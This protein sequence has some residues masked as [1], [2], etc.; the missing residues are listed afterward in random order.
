MTHYL[1]KAASEDADWTIDWATKGLGADTIQSFT[2]S[3]L[4]AGL[5]PAD[6][7]H[8]DATTTLWFSGGTP[9]MR[10]LVKFVVTTAGGRELPDSLTIFVTG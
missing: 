3:V 9:G 7:S 2:Y 6:P 8:T 10:Y 1:T 5:V 4:P